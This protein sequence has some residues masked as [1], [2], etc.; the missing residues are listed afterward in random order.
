MQNAPQQPGDD[1]RDHLV[2]GIAD[3]A[4]D[5]GRLQ[6]IRSSGREIGGQIIR[7]AAGDVAKQI[8]GDGRRDQGG[9]DTRQQTGQ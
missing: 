9:A 8:R 6:E 7:A 5:R 3:E 4:L 1:E 2:Q